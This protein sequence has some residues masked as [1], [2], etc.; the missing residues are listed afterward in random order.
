[1][2]NLGGMANIAKMLP[3]NLLGNNA[4]DV[5]AQIAQVE[6]RLKKYKAMVS[7]MN[8]LE[9]ANPDLLIRD[10]D[11]RDRLIR[12]TKGSGTTL[13]DG[14]QFI[15]EFQQMRTMMSR[16]SKKMGPMAAANANNNNGGDGEM[17]MPEMGNRA[18]RRATGKKSKKT[19]G[20]GGG[21]GFG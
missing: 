6:K 5:S 19:T 13:D 15:A 7:S 20:R 16:M 14:L 2:S 1:M 17:V 4:K 21:G 8:K 10:K 12:I 3:G 9:R 18:Q 11:A